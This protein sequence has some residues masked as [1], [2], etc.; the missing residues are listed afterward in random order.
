MKMNE[1]K[2]YSLK[3]NKD[4]FDAT[5]EEFSKKP[6]MLASLNDI[7]KNSHSNK[8]S[9]YYRFK[10]KKKLYFALIDDLYIQQIS[11]MNQQ[12]DFLVSN[13][14]LKQFLYVLFESLIAVSEKEPRYMTINRRIF[15][16]E[17][18]LQY[19][20]RSQC[21]LS[22]LDRF[23][24]LYKQSITS[25]EI[26]NSIFVDSIKIYYSHFDHF[27]HK[28]GFHLDD[29]IEFILQEKIDLKTEHPLKRPIFSAIN[30]GYQYHLS[31]GPL[32]NLTFHLYE[33]EIFALVGADS[34]GKSSLMKLIS[35]QLKKYEGSIEY[36]GIEQINSEYAHDIGFISQRPSIHYR[37]TVKDNLSLISKT[38][39]DSS[40]IE[41]MLKE[42]GLDEYKDIYVK[43]LS[44]D[45]QVLLD[46][47]RIEMSNPK[48]Y[49]IDIDIS[50]L[51]NRYRG[52][53]SRKLL[54]YKEKGSTIVLNDNKLDFILEISDRVAFINQGSIMK[55]VNSTD[56][57][58]KYTSDKVLVKYSI[59]E[60]H[61]QK[62]FRLD[63][64][65][66]ETFQEFIKNKPLIEINM[67]SKSYEEIYKLELGELQNEEY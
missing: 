29:F 48:I 38:K 52:I 22:P 27:W 65:N 19:E 35:G 31:T 24:S 49:I 50:T 14:S 15:S 13:L 30:I 11:Y 60:F 55:I 44:R 20:I 7:I 34:S 18:D 37:M 25:A 8:G 61:H 64:I 3:S 12:F 16:E 58:R 53:I 9:F 23:V 47:L 63:E 56:L 10:D 36:L 46:L 26:Y 45:A 28:P 2:T 1:D 4:L 39:F 57:Q 32:K 42:V 62:T 17:E 59:G 33:G 40:E 6:F 51:N 43:D 54:K 21:I 66:S 5:L 41:D 67:L